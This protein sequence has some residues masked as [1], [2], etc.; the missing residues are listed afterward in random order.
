MAFQLLPLM[1][2]V[3]EEKLRSIQNLDASLNLF[4]IFTVL[5]GFC[6]AANLTVISIKNTF[7]IFIDVTQ[8]LQLLLMSP[9]LEFLNVVNTSY[10]KS[11]F[12]IVYVSC[13]LNQEKCG[14]SMPD[15]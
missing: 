7:Y 9:S 15:I 1:W 5:S 14:F 3:P 11:T 12:G 13:L 4:F 8:H 6:S 10:G 2:L